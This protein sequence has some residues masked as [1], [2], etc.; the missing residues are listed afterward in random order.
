MKIIKW[1]LIILVIIVLVI[2]G[3]LAYMGM[4]GTLKVSERE[5]GPFDYVY[6]RYVGEYKNTGMVFS[7]LYDQLKKDGIST[8]N[9]LGIYYDDPVKVAKDK[10]RSDCGIVIQGKDLA[11]L[12]GLKQR[13]NVGHLPKKVCVIVEF[14]LINQLSLMLGPAK[15][16]P[17]L[18][19]YAQEHNY[20]MTQPMEFYDMPGGKILYF[21]ERQPK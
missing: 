16:Y 10:L 19:K 14:P 2:A 17:A 3:F 20:K 4:F 9:G 5:I 8:A 21:M 1:L 18:T 6:E 7:L 15:G 12:T 11:K 13:Y